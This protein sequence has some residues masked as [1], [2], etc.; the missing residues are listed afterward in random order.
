MNLGRGVQFPTTLGGSGLSLLPAEIRPRNLSKIIH[1][2]FSFHLGN[3]Q[4]LILI[5]FVNASV[6]WFWLTFGPE[7]GSRAMVGPPLLPSQAS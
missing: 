7:E 3:Q 5:S 2:S 6:L 4:G 1:L